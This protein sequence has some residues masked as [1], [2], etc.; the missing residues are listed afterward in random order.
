MLAGIKCCFIK[1]STISTHI[2]VPLHIY[3]YMQVHM[4]V[5]ACTKLM[6]MLKCIYMFAYLLTWHVE[7]PLDYFPVHFASTQVHT[8]HSSAAISIDMN[9]R[10]CGVLVQFGCYQPKPKYNV[11]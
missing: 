10:V 9:G 1:M 2:K 11:M 7:C 5:C 3:M 8:S 6:Y 4:H